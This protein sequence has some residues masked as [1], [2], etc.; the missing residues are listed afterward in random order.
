MPLRRPFFLY[1]NE[2][3]K[4]NAEDLRIQLSP[5]E[6]QSKEIRL[7]TLIPTY[8]HN[9]DGVLTSFALENISFFIKISF[10]LLYIMLIMIFKWCN[11]HLNFFSVLISNKLNI[12]NYNPYK[13]KLSGVLSSF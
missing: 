9:N 7:Q 5:I 2:N 13:H 1:F 6:P 10:M 3:N 8:I 4:L 12:D 11:K